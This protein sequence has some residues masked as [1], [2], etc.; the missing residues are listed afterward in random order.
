FDKRTHQVA[1]DTNSTN[2]SPPRVAFFAQL[3]FVIGMRL[4]QTGYG[5]S[6]GQH[7][8]LPRRLT[9]EKQSA[10]LC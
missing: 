6:H 3:G 8:V 7:S 2:E 10:Y 1:Q 4:M 9:D 5:I